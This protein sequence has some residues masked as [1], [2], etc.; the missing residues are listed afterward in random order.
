MDDIEP[1]S[2]IWLALIILQSFQ[3]KIEYPCHFYRVSKFQTCL[4]LFFYD[5]V[6]SKLVL[7]LFSLKLK[8]EAGLCLFVQVI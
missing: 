1:H 6:E 5:D 7:V 2:Y 8:L 4:L 3:G